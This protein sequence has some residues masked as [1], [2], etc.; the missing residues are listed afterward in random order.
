MR[1][2]NWEEYIAYYIELL[3]TKVGALQC[4]IQ[5]DAE[6]LPIIYAAY[7]RATEPSIRWALV[8][9][10][11]EH[12]EPSSVPFLAR[13]LHDPSDEVWNEAITGLVTIGSDDARA[14]LRHAVA[15]SSDDKRQRLEE[16]ERSI[17]R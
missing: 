5:V 11:W 7:D 17:R 16:A 12:R 4:L 15:G 6:A 10:V 3:P 13:A 8:K 9:A 2:I 1:E 14:A